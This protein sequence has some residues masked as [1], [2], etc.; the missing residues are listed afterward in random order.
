M[1]KFLIPFLLCTTIVFAESSADNNK[2]I[3]DTIQKSYNPNVD[4]L[5]LE[6]ENSIICKFEVIKD[7]QNEQKIVINWVN[8]NGEISRTREMLIP[9]GDSSAYDFRYLDGRESGKWDFKIIYN[10]KEYSTSF[11]LK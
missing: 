4:C 10:E 6:D 9:A 7:S 5:I 1:I 3:E 2:K 8:P 11:E